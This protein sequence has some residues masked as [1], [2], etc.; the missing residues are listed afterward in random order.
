MKQNVERDHAEGRI[1]KCDD[2]RLDVVVVNAVA[3]AQHRDS[4]LRS[5]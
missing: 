3:A 1:G 4:S 5:E 2:S